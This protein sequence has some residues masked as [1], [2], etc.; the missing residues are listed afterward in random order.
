MPQQK[1]H[2][3]IERF[4]RRTRHKDLNDIVRRV[5]AKDHLV[6]S[7]YNS[8]RFT[9]EGVYNIISDHVQ[10]RWVIKR[11]D[12]VPAVKQNYTLHLQYT[13]LLK[14]PWNRPRRAYSK[15]WD[16]NVLNHFTCAPKR[17]TF[18]TANETESLKNII[19]K[20]KKDVQAFKLHG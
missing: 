11:I 20:K 9:A 8:V 19:V 2:F 4:A 18:F 17:N 12:D 5:F 15:S 7:R 6:V 3:N 13:Q 16:S 1:F 10:L 14:S